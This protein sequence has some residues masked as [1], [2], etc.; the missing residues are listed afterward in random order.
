MEIKKCIQFNRH[1]IFL[2]PG[3]NSD[4]LLYAP[5]LRTLLKIRDRFA[6]RISENGLSQGV[7]DKGVRA[8]VLL[9]ERSLKDAIKPCPSWQGN[10][11]YV[12]Y[13]R[14]TAG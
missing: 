8:V 3:M 4:F 2:I 1:D 12:P 7:T 11:E 14:A 13:L 6:F 9:L 5:T 10:Y